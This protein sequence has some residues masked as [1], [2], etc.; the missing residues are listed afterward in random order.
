V[1]KEV[2][3]EVP[4][5]KSRKRTVRQMEYCYEAELEGTAWLIP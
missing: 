2:E 5:K 3:E 4:G 1:E